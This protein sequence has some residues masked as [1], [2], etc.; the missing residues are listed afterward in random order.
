MAHRI[1]P[2]K[3]GG[4]SR[5]RCALLTLPDYFEQTSSGRKRKSVSH[6]YERKREQDVGHPCR[7]IDQHRVFKFDDELNITPRVPGQ[8]AANE[9]SEHINDD[10]ETTPPERDIKMAIYHI[11][12][13]NPA[14][15]DAVSFNNDNDDSTAQNPVVAG[16]SHDLP[17]IVGDN[18]HAKRFYLA[19]RRCATK[20]C[21]YTGGEAAQNFSTRL[22]NVNWPEGGN[23]PHGYN[24]VDGSNN[25]GLNDAPGVREIRLVADDERMCVATYHQPPIQGNESTLGNIYL[26]CH[27]AP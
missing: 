26:V 27:D 3:S 23:S 17:Q 1:S 21:D 8:H 18:N 5:S 11:N 24:G 7:K 2:V 14:W 9:C 16:A 13:E 25:E 20:R 10:P 4:R 22:V 19:W 12:A 6:Q 15:T